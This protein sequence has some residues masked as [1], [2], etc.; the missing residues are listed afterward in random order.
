MNKHSKQD[1][2]LASL[3]MAQLKQYCQQEQNDNNTETVIAFLLL[4]IARLHNKLAEI[5]LFM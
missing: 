3:L 1:F 2:E 5:D 4:E